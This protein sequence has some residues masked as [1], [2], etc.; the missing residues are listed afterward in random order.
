MGKLRP[1]VRRPMLP[2][3][4]RARVGG[5][6]ALGARDAK[7]LAKLT[8]RRRARRGTTSTDRG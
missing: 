8:R 6:T 5:A 1:Q 7:A 4:P 3:A 2:G